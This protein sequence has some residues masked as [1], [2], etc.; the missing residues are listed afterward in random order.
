MMAINLTSENTVALANAVS[1]KDF[2]LKQ[3]QRK[4]QEFAS[5]VETSRWNYFDAV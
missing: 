3:L 5:F 1:L 2:L 4:I